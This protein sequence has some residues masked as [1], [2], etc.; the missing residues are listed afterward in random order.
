MSALELL[1]QLER[2][3]FTLTPTVDGKLAVKPAG[4]LTDSLR[5]QIRA[6]KAEV[7]ALLTKLYLTPSGEL[8][9]PFTSDPKYHWVGRRPE[10]DGNATRTQRSTR[11]VEA[12][13]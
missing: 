9:I 11:S 8:H 10:S 3:G 2:Q 1:R 6:H 12:I 4:R 13:H 7:V 5:K